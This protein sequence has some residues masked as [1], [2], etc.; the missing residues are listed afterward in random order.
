[1]GDKTKELE[2]MAINQAISYGNYFQMTG[3]DSYAFSVRIRRP[4]MI[5]RISANFDL[6]P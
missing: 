6:R 2:R 5:R 3:W 4:D 1:M